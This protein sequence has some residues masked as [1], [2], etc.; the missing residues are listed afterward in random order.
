MSFDRLAPHYRWME[1]LLAGQKLQACRSAWLARVPDSREVL[2]VGEGPGRFLALCATVLPEARIVCVDASAAMLAR[3]QSAWQQAG[4]RADRITF[5]HARLPEWQPETQRFDLIV[6]H[7]FLDCF[8]PRLLQEVVAT[9][10]AG[11]TPAA[12]WLLADFQLPQGGMRRIRAR[13]VLAAA[14]AF[15][16]LATRLPASQLSF[17]DHQLMNHGFRREHWLEADWGLLRSDLWTRPKST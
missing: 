6:T 7:F 10:S 16:R 17:P 13:V 5:V 8:P 11:A 3:A 9:L 15:F 14:Y 2:I 1:F 4:G 12:R